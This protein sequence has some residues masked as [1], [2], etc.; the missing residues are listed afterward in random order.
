ME[1][2]QT[3]GP[4]KHEIDQRSA[5][6]LEISLLWHEKTNELSVF[7]F[8]SKIGDSFE[9]PVAKDDALDV[10]HHPYAYAAFRGLEVHAGADAKVAIYA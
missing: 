7:V 3:Y 2:T 1:L 5:D 9:L 10:F 4:G 8:D 6:G